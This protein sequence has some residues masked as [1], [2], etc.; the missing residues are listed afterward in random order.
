[1][2]IVILVCLD[3]KQNQAENVTSITLT[4]IPRLVAPG[5]HLSVAP[6]GMNSFRAWFGAVKKL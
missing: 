1:M 5:W 6:T 4:K 3:L 2:R